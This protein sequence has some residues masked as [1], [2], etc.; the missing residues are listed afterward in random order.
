[1]CTYSRPRVPR[2]PGPRR[3]NNKRN[4][5]YI[6]SAT[7]SYAVEWGRGSS[8]NFGVGWRRVAVELDRVV[9]VVLPRIG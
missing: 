3:S 9:V 7:E 2:R 6:H 4:M 1:M 5:V 8:V